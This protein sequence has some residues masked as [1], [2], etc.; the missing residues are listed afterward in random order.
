MRSYKSVTPYFYRP[1]HTTYVLGQGVFPAVPVGRRIDKVE[2]READLDAVSMVT[3][4]S[5]ATRDVIWV[6]TGKTGRRERSVDG[7][8]R[9]EVNI[10]GL[11]CQPDTIHA[12]THARTHM[13]AFS[14]GF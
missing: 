5:I 3:G 12:R 9:R 1:E 10:T 6:R 7:R 14:S 4:E 2:R 13:K 8:G 11:R